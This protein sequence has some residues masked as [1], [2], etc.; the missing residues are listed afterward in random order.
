MS[1]KVLIIIIS[2]NSAEYIGDCLSSLAKI[3][4]PAS[5]FKILV[6]DNASM[7]NS[8]ELIEA[9]YPTVEL[10]KN[11][12]NFGF[13]GG[14]NLGLQRAIEQ[15][16]DYAYL[17]NQ[18]TVVTPEFLTEAVK[19]IQA[20]P[21]IAAVQSKLLLFDQK[22]KINSWGNEIH[23]LGF[24]FAG[25]YLEPDRN[26]PVKEI[27]YPSGAA[28]LISLAALKK[29]GLFNPEFFMYHE[30]VDL[31]WR[32]W[33][34]GY[35]VMLAPKSVV[36]HKYEFSRSI[37]KYYFMERNR[38]LVLLQNY[39]LATLIVIFPAWLLMDLAM[40]FYSF[41]AGWWREELK[42]CW[43]L[44][45]SGNWGKI[46]RSRQ[47]VQATRK[48]SDRQLIRRWVS[49]IEFQEIASPILK[50]LVNPALNLYWQ[51]V[52]RLIFW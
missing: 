12:Q 34:A 46:W 6:V 16:F 8:L 33:L 29:I 18:D 49:K 37:K 41:I 4:Y 30:D 52:K 14:N 26:L 20:D 43:Y 15:N 17:L 36:Y 24:A 35:R 42:V 27:A 10:I 32:L 31:G 22:D 51:V 28:V 40:F 38:R 25:G 45:N 50:Y 7:D 13:V 5:D 9:S 19:S 11:Q 23:Y 21:A 48:I 2:H 39:R 1:P 3:N 44:I 47:R